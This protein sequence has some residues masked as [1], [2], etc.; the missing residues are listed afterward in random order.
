MIQ[1]K[2]ISL[3]LPLMG[4][5]R[6][7]AG[8]NKAPGKFPLKTLAALQAGI[9]LL[10]F[11]T[12]ALT[13]SGQKPAGVKHR[14]LISYVKPGIGT[15]HSRWF[16]YTPAA[17]PQG[18][19]KLAPSTNGHFGNASGWEA[20]GY[21]PRDP[22]ME[23]FVLFH[24]WQLGG[25]LVTATN[26]P[27][28]T[29]PGDTTGIAA[30]KKYI[31][32]RSRYSHQKEQASPGYY[33]VTLDD[34]Q[35]KAALT[36]TKHVGFLKFTFPG[37]DR[38]KSGARII[39][40]IGSKQGESG[41]VR[42]AWVKMTDDTH[43]EGY[44]STFPKYLKTNDPGGQVDMYIYGEISEQPE[45]V[46]SFNG[47]GVHKGQ[48]QGSGKGAGLYLQLSDKR[49]AGKPVEVKI[50]GSYTSI[51][52]A[53]NNFNREA[54]GLSFD[55]AKAA[56]QRIWEKKLGAVKVVS[57]NEKRKVK[58]YTGMFHALLGRGV[59]SDVSGDYPKGNGLVGHIPKDAD[60][61]LK[62][63]AINTDAIWG[64]YWNL[65]QLWALAYPDYYRDFVY[66][67]LAQ[68][69]N[70]GWFADGL[71][72]GQ[73]A[74]GV[75]TN[76][77]G[78]AIAA[79]Y[80]CGLL[81]DASKKELSLAYAAVRK[82]ELGWENRPVGAGK[83]DIAIFL[84]SGYVPF[85][86]SGKST[87]R[88]SNFSASHTLEYG[89]GA[90]AAAE[91]AARLGKSKDQQLFLKYAAG[92]RKLFDSS[93]QLIRPKDISGK[94]IENYDPYQPWR[95]FQEG[96]GMQY[97]FFVPQNPEGLIRAMGKDSFNYRLNQ[98]FKHS[99]QQAFGGGK[100]INAF[101]GVKA[102]YNHGNQPDMQMSWL[103]NFSGKPWLTQ[104]WTRA[105][106]DQFYGAERIHGYGY[107]QDEDQGQLGSWLVMS[108]LG[109]F[110]VKGFTDAR[111]VI[112]FGSPAFDTATVQLGN[113]GTLIITTQA[114]SDADIYIQSAKWNGQPLHNAWMY[115]DELM[116]GG[117]LEFIMGDQPNKS[118]GVRVPPPSG[119]H[120]K[121]MTEK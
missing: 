57:R 72:N 16:F 105:I 61:H 74:S 36:A 71:V 84:D 4:A 54:A 15:A 65:T 9:C 63:E 93:L 118:F 56:T 32:Y 62:Y 35:I 44:V 96:N 76:F 81:K 79:A 75:G 87:P 103:F 42:D 50:G 90:Y 89:F 12:P 24:E 21:D 106:C 5:P 41:E 39:L 31:G 69:Q 26:G 27:L 45:S 2:D 108:S 94:F 40:D 82:N 47:E 60:G 23:G 48:R 58:F 119:W 97:T 1:T 7:F 66:T 100:E 86:D 19:I 38:K 17:A 78:L 3:P 95:G 107:G 28:H 112:E 110:D 121:L 117:H 92:W 101:S 29:K 77:V 11:L 52:N 33:Q 46:G 99:E 80:Q 6:Q 55:Q 22:T 13:A 49:S 85:I 98:L 53:R 34:Y 25:V 104:K 111:P 70:R 68:Y 10:L 83:E 8:K 20:V 114:D 109:L 91:M 67:Q 18:M 88:G 59:A 51:K 64:G 30:G 115:R 116:K 37:G 113:G 102:V 14:S 43:F 73:Y 120:E